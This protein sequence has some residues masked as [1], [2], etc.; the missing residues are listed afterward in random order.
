M[1]KTLRNRKRALLLPIPVKGAFDRVA[2]DCLGPFP[3]SYSGT[4]YVVVFFDYLTRW[5]EAFAVSTIDAVV[6]A[7]LL[8]SEIFCR[9]GSPKTLLPDHG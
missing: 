8:V 2:V 9:H 5:P 6:I 4:R 3:E 1:R 7:K